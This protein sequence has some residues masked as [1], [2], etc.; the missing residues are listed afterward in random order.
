M[1]IDTKVKGSYAIYKG[2]ELIA[3]FDNLITNYGLE[4][5]G[6]GSLSDNIVLGSDA[7]APSR[8]DTKLGDQFAQL[9]ATPT[10]LD[11]IDQEDE[12]HYTLTRWSATYTATSD[13]TI[14]EVGFG[15][16]GSNIFSRALPLDLD[17]NTTTLDI[18]D[19]ESITIVYHLAGSVNFNDVVKN[20]YTVRPYMRGV[21]RGCRGLLNSGTAL[22]GYSGSM[23]DAESVSLPAGL[24][25]NNQNGVKSVGGRSIVFEIPIVNYVGFYKTF[26]LVTPNSPIGYQ[27]ELNEVAEKT[28]DEEITLAFKVEWSRA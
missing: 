10:D 13:V 21:R 7:K 6:V 9:T 23:V 8:S 1:T 4:R 27:F 19:G 26:T 22:R 5:L 2:G 24:L 12:T 25:Y 20:G 11:E 15:Y 18:L 3:K 14:K 16:T 17:G 28:A